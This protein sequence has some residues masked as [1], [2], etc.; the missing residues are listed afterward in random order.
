MGKGAYVRR[1]EKEYRITVRGDIP[2]DL[3]DRVSQLHADAILQAQ[4]RA[5]RQDHAADQDQ[6]TE[7]EVA[8]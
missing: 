8:L 3:V 6:A 1:S 2:P 4:A 7:P 5:A